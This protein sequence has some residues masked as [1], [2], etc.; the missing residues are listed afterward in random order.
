MERRAANLESA[1]GQ[2]TRGK[3]TDLSRLTGDQLHKR[4]AELGT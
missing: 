3:D 1:V 2:N 4:L